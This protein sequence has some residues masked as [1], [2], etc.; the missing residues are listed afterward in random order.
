ME[1]NL[2]SF[3]SQMNNDNEFLKLKKI[4]MLYFFYNL[5]KYYSVIFF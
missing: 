3:D 4:Q 5:D 2:S 1:L